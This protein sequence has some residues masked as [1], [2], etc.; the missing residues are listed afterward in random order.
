MIHPEQRIVVV[1]EATCHARWLRHS[2]H[3]LNP[4]EELFTVEPDPDGTGE[5][6]VTV[7]G[8]CGAVDETDSQELPSMVGS[9]RDTRTTC[10]RCGSTVTT[11]PMFGAHLTRTP[12]PPDPAGTPSRPDLDSATEPTART[13]RPARKG[14]Q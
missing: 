11:D 14:T 1:Y 9:G 2:L 3:H 7:C 4:V 12:W 8:V 10:Q 5:P 6:A 13:T